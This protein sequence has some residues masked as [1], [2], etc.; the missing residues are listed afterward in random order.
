MKK[1]INPFKGL[2][3]ACLCAGP[4]PEHGQRMVTILKR[5]EPSPKPI[6][7]VPTTGYPLKILLEI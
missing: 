6:L 1:H 4:F 7:S 2:V 5:S 3:L